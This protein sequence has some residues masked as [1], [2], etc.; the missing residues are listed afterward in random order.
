MRQK[1][2][3]FIPFIALVMFLSLAGLTAQVDYDMFL[4]HHYGDFTFYQRQNSGSGSI[5]YSLVSGGSNPLNDVDISLR[6]K[7]CFVDIDND[8][9]M[10][11]FTAN[12]GGAIQ[13]WKNTGT[14]TSP[15]FVEQTSS[16][17]PLNLDLG[18]KV[19]I[20]FVDIDGDGDMDC[21]IG[22]SNGYSKYYENTGSSSEPSFTSRSDLIG[23]VGGNAIPAFADLDGDGE[24]CITDS[25]DQNSDGT[26]QDMGAYQ[27]NL[28]EIAERT[29]EARI[30]EIMINPSVLDYEFFE[31]HN[32]S[33]DA[34]WLHEWSFNINDVLTHTIDD[35]NLILGA[36]EYRVLSRSDNTCADC[37]DVDY[38]YT[39]MPPFNNTQGTLS[40]YDFN[41]DQEDIFT[42]NSDG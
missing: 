2:K 38:T 20:E 1:S 8:G 6:A 10:D 26:C 12:S 42:Y 27:T 35:V 14:S 25:D 22:N 29:G 11:F 5:S 23:D 37:W 16:D 28:F 7:I 17:N 9:D 30:N 36:G 19:N 34:V 40:I 32:S 39:A 4:G 15:T 31:L 3:K 18:S 24:S 13:H 33:E 21:F 41:G